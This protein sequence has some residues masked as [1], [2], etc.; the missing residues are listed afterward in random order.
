MQQDE[1]VQPVPISHWKRC[2]LVA[3]SWFPKEQTEWVD[4]LIETSTEKKS[5]LNWKQAQ[6]TRP[7]LQRVR[8][9]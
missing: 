3:V 1:Q 8:A 4:K 5:T 2:R 6:E 9:Y 7:G